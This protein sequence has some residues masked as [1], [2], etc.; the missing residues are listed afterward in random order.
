MDKKA[1]IIVDVQN[2]FCPGGALAVKD[3]DQVVAPLNRLSNAVRNRPDWLVFA[4]RDWHPETTSHFGA[5]GGLWPV[6]CVRNT[7]GA[8]FHPDLDISGAVLVLKG[9]QPGEDAYSAFDGVIA[10]GETLEQVLTANQV[11]E[12]V[13]GGLAT[14]YCVKATVLDALKRG[15][16]VTLV[17]DACRAVDLK[18]GDELKAINE[19]IDN[20]VNVRITEE[21]INELDN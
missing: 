17:T 16:R 8:E 13:V 4:S 10:S 9:T 20:G 19:M 7:K 11:V 2:D 3:G 1:L 6:H 12:L 14:D 5:Y 18:P 15:F 21:V